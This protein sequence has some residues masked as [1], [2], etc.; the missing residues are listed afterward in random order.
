MKKAWVILLAFLYLGMCTGIV[1]NYHY[2][3]G[4]L[5]SVEWGMDH[6]DTCARCGM[7]DKSGC[8]ET[9]FQVVKVQQEHQGA[10]C[11]GLSMPLAVESLTHSVVEGTPFSSIETDIS[12][13]SVALH[14]DG[15]RRHL[16]LRV[17]RI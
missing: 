15:L 14:P 6:D 11:E 4:D 10:K 5:A 12:P 17:F 9:K 3:M 1:V 7:K 13:L 8:C 16:L 2:C